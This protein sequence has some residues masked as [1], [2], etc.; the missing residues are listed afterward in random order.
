MK[1]Q[2]L[3]TALTLGIAAGLAGTADV[4]SAGSPDLSIAAKVKGKP[5]SDF[6]K[7]HLSEGQKKTVKLKVT[8]SVPETGAETGAIQQVFASPSLDCTGYKFRYFNKNGTNITAAVQGPEGHPVTVQPD[9]PKRFTMTVKR[10]AGADQRTYQ[11]VRVFDENSDNRDAVVDIN[12][13]FANCN[14]GP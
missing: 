4:A 11:I 7:F 14:S 3:L 5:F 9:K 13:G 1:R 12:N 2:L 8:V 6:T 10:P